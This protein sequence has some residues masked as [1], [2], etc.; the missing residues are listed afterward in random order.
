MPEE[1]FT[2]SR[3]VKAKVHLEPLLHG[4]HPKTREVIPLRD[5]INDPDINGA[6]RIAI[7]SIDEVIALRGR[8]Q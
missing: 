8:K 6:L 5:V 4:I 7:E 3:L 1:D 2:I